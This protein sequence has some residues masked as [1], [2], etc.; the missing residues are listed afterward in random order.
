MNFVNQTIR[1][2]AISL[3]IVFIAAVLPR[4]LNLGAILSP[5]EPQWEQNVIGFREALESGD[6]RGLYQQP[7]PGIPT[8][9]LTAPVIESESWAVKRLPY[10]L[11]NSLLV[12][13]ATWIAGRIWGWKLGG[14]A[15][16][17]LALNPYFIAHSRVLAMDAMLSIFLVITLLAW[18]AWWQEKKRYW[19]FISAA[20]AAL[21]ILS[22]L[23]GVVVLPLLLAHAIWILFRKQLSLREWSRAASIWTAC[24]LLTLVLVFPTLI[25]DGTRVINEFLTFFRSDLYINAVHAF[26]PWWYPQALLLWTTPLHLLAALFLPF[27]LWKIPQWRRPILF[28]SSFSLVF[29]LFVQFSVKKGDRYLLP[30]FLVFDLL[31]VLTIASVWSIIHQRWVKN[32]ILAL[33]TLAGVWQLWNLF[34]LHPHYLAYRNPFFRNV[35]EGRTMGWGEGLDLAAEYLNQKP[36]AEEMLVISYYENSFAHRFVG[37]FTSAERLAKETPEEIGGDYVVLYRTM[38]G[39]APDRWETKAL[40]QFADKTPEHVI[41]LNGEE[42]VWIYAIK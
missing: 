17:L 15:G 26:G 1:T 11:A 25:T 7:H 31:G 40:A 35:A 6:T 3:L 30:D 9:W 19:L 36:G 4:V 23:A 13:A 8:M 24:F 20:A 39:R 12:V 2:L 34:E 18:L 14:V 29:F 32:V 38:E 42:Y 22:K 21:A 10:A 16:L 5:D 41:I 37:E 28:L 27:V 33:V